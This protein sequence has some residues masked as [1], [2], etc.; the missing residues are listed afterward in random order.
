VNW[1]NG[2][3][4]WLLLAV[5]SICLLGYILHSHSGIFRE[6]QAALLSPQLM[7][8]LC[9]AVWCGTFLFLTFNLKDLPLIGLLLICIIWFFISQAESRPATDAITLLFGVTLGRGA[10]VLLRLK[11][12]REMLKEDSD[13][14]FSVQ[15]SAFSTFLIGLVL[16]LAFSAFWHLDMSNNF[17]HGTRWMGLWNNPNDYGMLMGAGTLL[18][19]G[20]LAASLK[21]S[22]QG[23]QSEENL[24]AESG[25]REITA[26]K[27]HQE[28][29]DHSVCSLRPFLRSLRSFAAK[30]VGDS[31]SLS[32]RIILF[33][34]AFM[35]GVGLVMSYSRGAWLGT[36][37][38]LLYLAKHTKAESGTCLRRAPARQER[39]AKMVWYLAPMI[40][41]AT[42]VIVFC[43]KTPDTAPWY[44]K[45]LDL[46]R[47]SV[48]HRVAAWKAGFEMMRDHP[49]GVGWNKTVPIYQEH[50]SPPE[51]GAAAITTNDY[52]MLGTQIGIPALVCFVAYVALCFR[53]PRPTVHSLQSS[54]HSPQ[55][56]NYSPQSAVISPQSGDSGLWTLDS[57]LRIACR[58]GA[59]V[60]LVAFWFDGG[61][62]KLA[63]ASVFWIFLELG[64][65]RQ[66]LKTEMLKAEIE[67]K[68]ETRNLRPEA[69]QKAENRNQE[70]I[71]TKGH[72]EHKENP[73]S[74]PCPSPHP[75]RQGEGLLWPL[76]S[77]AAIK[78]ESGRQFRHLTPAL[79]PNEAEREPKSEIGNQETDTT[80]PH[81]PHPVKLLFSPRPSP[82]FATLSRSRGRG[83]IRRERRGNLV[84]RNPALVTS[85][86]YGF[87]LVELLVVI[88]II[89]I[90]AGLLM[91]GLSKAKLKAQGTIC[92]NNMKQLQLAAILYGSNN[93]DA[94]PA[95]ITLRSGGDTASGKPNWL[96]GTCSSAPPW[97]NAIAEDPVGCATNPFYLG[98]WGNTGGNPV[99]TLMGSIGPYAKS[100]GVYH[101]PADTYQDPA[102]HLLRV[103]SCSANCFVGGNGPEANGVNGQQN[104]VNYMVFNK[105]WDFGGASL[106]ASDCFVY[107]DENPL[108]LNDG[109]FLFYASGSTINDKPAINHGLSSSFSFAD[110][111]AEF[112]LWHDVFLDPSLT[113]GSSGGIDTQWLAQHGTYPLQ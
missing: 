53:S 111:H 3:K 6:L 36:A 43:W 41:I 83:T 18:A 42:V 67:K 66:K 95:N 58:A 1:H 74:S 27:E 32:L 98:V 15:H 84:T 26:T 59:L 60:F 76:R 33:I 70:I 82:G 48:Q 103:R 61:L 105:F 21:S 99:V 92:L 94:L 28:H 16:L 107:L 22:V 113:P 102:W 46:S 104:G 9:L 71:A 106:G 100:A 35:M 13:V 54:V 62:F 56:I 75:T 77:F 80:S 88:A 109:W 11:A 30:M 14:K 5:V 85:R 51:D 8:L 7:L 2:I 52:L 31:R 87:T 96:D 17:Y 73:D 39:K 4:V 69:I 23:P 34:A 108:S 57:R 63:T 37:I 93:N 50:Y 20:L 24:K 65:E 90:L 19:V 38:G 10:G 25:K 72:K 49:F 97:N 64:A 68:P 47:G 112:Q 110:G 79:S 101:C 86:N 55:S 81:P 40:I 89:G 91:P 45:R 78:S 29:K 12:K 44:V